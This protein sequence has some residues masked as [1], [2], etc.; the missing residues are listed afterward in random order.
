MQIYGGFMSHKFFIFLC[1]TFLSLNVYAE[2]NE[3]EKKRDQT[4]DL[5]IGL[6]GT[7][8]NLGDRVIS[9][10]SAALAFDLKPFFID[11]YRLKG[12]CKVIPKEKSAVARVVGAI[13]LGQVSFMQYSFSADIISPEGQ[14]SGQFACDFQGT[15]KKSVKES[16][17]FG[18][19][20]KVLVQ[21][22]IACSIP[23]NEKLERIKYNP[24]AAPELKKDV[25]I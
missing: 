6:N 25:A 24:P 12:D 20:L 16:I 15:L 5:S 8:L 3:C 7:E 9:P 23:H 10:N 11:G 2:E 19:F 17:L 1:A 22:N 14:L 18:D 4:A 21:N 13:R